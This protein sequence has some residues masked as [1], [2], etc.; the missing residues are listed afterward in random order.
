MHLAVSMQR[1]C[2]QAQHAGASPSIPSAL[3]GSLGLRPEPLPAAHLVHSLRDDDRLQAPKRRVGKDESRP[4]APG[5]ELCQLAKHCAR[6]GLGQA[7][8]K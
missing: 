4:S 7:D 5:R 3:P 6:K 1:I 2:R 8:K